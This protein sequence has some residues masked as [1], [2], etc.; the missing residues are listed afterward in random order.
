VTKRKPYLRKNSK[1]L[2]KKLE[3]YAKTIEYHIY[4]G[5]IDLISFGEDLWWQAGVTSPS[6]TPV[7]KVRVFI[8]LELIEPLFNVNITLAERRI[9]E[10]ELARLILHETAVSYLPHDII[11]FNILAF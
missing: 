10:F 9:C 5:F 6:V 2:K 7:R 4:S 8:A 1:D 11:Y 3:E